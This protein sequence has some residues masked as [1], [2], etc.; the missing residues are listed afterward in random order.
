MS[1]SEYGNGSDSSENETIDDKMTKNKRSTKSKSV[2]KKIK[3]GDFIN[4]SNIYWCF[5]DTEDSDPFK[6]VSTKT[7]YKRFVII[8]KK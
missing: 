6:I 2:N 4:F 5:N 8:G 1:D 3:K 7:E